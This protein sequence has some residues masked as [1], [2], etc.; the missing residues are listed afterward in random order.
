MLT[1]D[2]IRRQGLRCTPF[3]PTTN[4]KRCTNAHFS[5]TP[6]L[7]YSVCYRAFILIT[8]KIYSRITHELFGFINFEKPNIFKS[9]KKDTKIKLVSYCYFF[10]QRVHTWSGKNKIETMYYFL[11]WRI[12]VKHT[13]SLNAL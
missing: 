3:Q 6:L 7:L 13:E 12:I 5:S 9:F 2:A 1:A 8:M 10:P 11:F 4:D